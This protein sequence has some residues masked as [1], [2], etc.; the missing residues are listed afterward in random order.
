MTLLF[1]PAAKEDLDYWEQRDEPMA[2]RI[3]Q[4][5]HKLEQGLALPAHQQTRLKFGSLFLMSL[6][7]SAEHRL[8]FE[9][10]GERIIV[11]QC[12]FHY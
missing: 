2:N 6:K 12:R 10:L 9:P 7:L 8:V 4:L 1:T 11:H 5:L 3:W